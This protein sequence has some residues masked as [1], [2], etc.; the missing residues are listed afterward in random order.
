MKVSASDFLNRILIE[1]SQKSS[2]SSTLGSSCV[3]RAH[4]FTRFSCIANARASA[5]EISSKEL[6]SLLAISLTFID[7][8]FLMRYEM[9]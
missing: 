8:E 9:S 6:L 5:L 7:V 3:S 4:P 2:S 1:G